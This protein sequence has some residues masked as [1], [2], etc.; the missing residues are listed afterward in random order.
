MKINNFNDLYL[1]GLQQ[2]VS[3]ERQ[4][5]QSLSSMAEMASLFALNETMRSQPTAVRRP[6][7]A[8]LSC[9]TMSMCSRA[10]SKEEKEADAMPNLFA[11]REVNPNAVAA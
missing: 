5:T 7:R 6:S 3:V 9:V 2:L 1:A 4:L 10:P 11:K 8:S